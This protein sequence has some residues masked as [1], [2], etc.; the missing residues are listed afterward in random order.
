MKTVCCPFGLTEEQFK[1]W[2]EAKRK[3]IERAFSVAQ[4]KGHC[5][6]RK[7]RKHAIKDAIKDAED[8]VLACVI[9]HNMMV[10]HRVERDEI[11]E[12]GFY[13]VN[14]SDGD[15]LKGDHILAQVEQ[16]DAGNLLQSVMERIGNIKK[17]YTDHT[18]VVLEARWEHLQDRIEH[19][20]LKRCVM[21]EL[22]GSREIL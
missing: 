14:P 21:K 13:N 17:V 10:E 12:V 4:I 1:K 9:L 15:P 18:S 6:Q 16:H 11:E 3:C 2:Q 7:C 5:L 8:M 20:R 22:F 19:F